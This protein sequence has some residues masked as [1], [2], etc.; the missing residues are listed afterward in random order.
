LE[1]T[2]SR[3]AL[4]GIGLLL[5]C[6]GTRGIC[7]AGPPVEGDPDLVKLLLDTQAKNAAGYKEGRLVATVLL[8]DGNFAGDVEVVWQ[9]GRSRW[10]VMYKYRGRTSRQRVLVVEQADGSGVHFLPDAYLVQRVQ[11]KGPNFPDALRVRPADLWFQMGGW[12]RKYGGNGSPLEEQLG[13]EKAST[14][15]RFRI[16]RRG[17]EVDFERHY[18]N[19][20]MFLVTAS[21]AAG[22]NVISYETARL[23][24]LP[25]ARAR[26]PV[27]RGR[28]EW[29]RAED[30]TF[31]LRSCDFAQTGVGL[32][33]DP[34]PV[35]RYM[36]S[37]FDP[38]PEIPDGYLTEDGLPV[39]AGTKVEEYGERYKIRTFYTDVGRRGVWLPGRSDGSD[40]LSA[41]EPSE[42]LASISQGPVKGVPVEAPRPG[43]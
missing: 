30:G 19:G 39:P 21:L 5:L 40:G 24:A 2:L 26:W 14:V 38:T 12:S 10:D 33:F 15:E 36:A 27:R 13:L 25:E 4:F 8:A 42:A 17:D 37:E 35:Y 3:L 20:A 28:Y 41:R 16:V 22:G 23:P 43:L 31:W 6:F 1:A 29:A 34:D 11:P 9:G 18:R 32:A 7:L